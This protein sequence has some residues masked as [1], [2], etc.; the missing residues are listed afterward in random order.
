LHQLGLAIYA[1]V[2]LVVFSLSGLLQM[3]EQQYGLQFATKLYLL[4][5]FPDKIAAEH[6]TIL[7]PLLSNPYTFFAFFPPFCFLLVIIRTTIFYVIVHHHYH[8]DIM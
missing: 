4:H 3:I 5:L 2:G 6:C 7:A 8:N 1:G